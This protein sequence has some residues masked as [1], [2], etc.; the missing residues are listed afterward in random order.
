MQRLLSVLYGLA[1]YAAML[2]TL[3]F[4]VGFSGDLLVPKSVDH[5]ASMLPMSMPMPTLVA[6]CVDT[7]LLALFG[8]QH[9]L[10]ARRGFKQWWTRVVQ[11][12]VERSTYMVFS[13]VVLW[14]MFAFWAPIDAPLVWHVENRIGTALTWAVFA[15]GWALAVAASYFIDHFELFGLRQVFAHLKRSPLPGAR[16]EIP[17]LYCY[18]R[19]P[20]YVGMLLGLWAAPV[21]TAGH[22]LFSTGLSVYILIG[23]AFEERDLLD[24]FG[25][26]YRRYRSQV[27]MLFPRVPTNG[28]RKAP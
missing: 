9:S 12:A 23:I 6:A 19:H 28:P 3:A 5:G 25:E 7:L 14:L 1:A 16:F 27:G 26:R 2:A 15:L 4:L 17:L 11:P 24:L 8:V 21:M 22:L 13:C 20:L 18:V 10:M